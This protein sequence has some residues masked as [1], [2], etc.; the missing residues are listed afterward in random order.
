MTE[1]PPPLLHYELTTDP[2]PPQASPASGNAKKLALTFVVS[3]AER[4]DVFCERITFH[5]DIGPA[6]S[7]SAIFLTSVGDGIGTV[8]PNPEGKPAGDWEL[9]TDIS[10]PGTYSFIRTSDDN[11]VS[12]RGYVFTISDI[13]VSSAVGTAKLTVNEFSSP[14]ANTTASL[15]QQIFEVP[16]F[17][18][19]FGSVVFKTDETSVEPEQGTTLHWEGDDTGTYTLLRNGKPMKAPFRSPRPTGPLTEDTVF[20]LRVGAPGVK[21]KRDYYATVLVRNPVV[22]LM[23]PKGPVR[24]GDSFTLKWHTE[25]VQDCFIQGPG[26]PKKKIAGRSQ[27][28]R[29]APARR[30]RRVPAERDDGLRRHDPVRVHDQGAAQGA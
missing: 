26:L 28:R 19:K 29:A 25:S 22:N 23:G 20:T 2:D 13:E 9:D 16:K 14:D 30:G 10:G 15:R 21:V 4:A 1:P 12:R 5:F 17:P 7:Q 8:P 27:A 3:P 18:W 6:G 24:S 11:K